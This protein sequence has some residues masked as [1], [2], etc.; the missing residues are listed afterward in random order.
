MS[1]AQIA[2]HM[3]IRGGVKENRVDRIEGHA[4]RDLLNPSDPTAA[5]NRRIEILLKVPKA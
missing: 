5:Q 4:D 3:L 2:Y 1:R